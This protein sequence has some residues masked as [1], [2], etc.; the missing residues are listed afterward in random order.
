MGLKFHRKFKLKIAGRY[1]VAVAQSVR[2]SEQY[3]AVPGPL[4]Q[5]ATKCHARLFER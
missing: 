4:E 5:V 2:L 3:L 1:K